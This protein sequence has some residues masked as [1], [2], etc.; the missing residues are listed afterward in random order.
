MASLLNRLARL[1]RVL[2]VVAGLAILLYGCSADDSPLGQGGADKP[3]VLI[4]HSYDNLFRWSAQQNDGIIEGLKRSGYTEDD[5]ELRVFYMDARVN[6]L[7]DEQIA[8]RT[9]IA[10]RTIDEFKPQVVF[11]T[12]DIAV[13]EVAVPYLEEHPDSEVSFV[14]SGV[15]GDPLKYPVVKSL[16]APGAKITGTLERIPFTEGLDA[17]RRV[18]S[19]ATRTVIFADDSTSSRTVMDSFRRAAFAGTT[20]PLDVVDFIQISTFEEWKQDVSAFEGRVDVIAVVNYH[21]IRDASGNIV[22]PKE[23]AK[24]T[25]ENSSAPAFGLISDWSADGLAM[26]FGNSGFETGVFIGQRGAAILNGADAGQMPIVDPKQYEMT[27]NLT[28]LE[29]EDISVP[30][31][32]LDKASETFK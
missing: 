8:L 20:Y 21:R 24:W 25:A 28:T 27:F 7:T 11:L 10:R 3:R 15:N 14:F 6:F 12:D 22:P 2:F 13:E 4:I 30:K 32:E 16:E 18:F 5:Y 19:P 26:S 17:G 23:V 1:S 9:S 31:A 29:K